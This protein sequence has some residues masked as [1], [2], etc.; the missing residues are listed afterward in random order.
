MPFSKMDVSDKFTKGD[1]LSTSMTALRNHTVAAPILTLWK[2]WLVSEGASAR[3]RERERESE[4][5]GAMEKTY[6]R[7]SPRNVGAI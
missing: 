7:W 3:E 4:S 1:E 2:P 6:K 5:E